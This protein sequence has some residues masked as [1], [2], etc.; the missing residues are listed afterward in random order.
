MDQRPG[1]GE[2]SFTCSAAQHSTA[3]SVGAF[4][5]LLTCLFVQVQ[6]PYSD[7]LGK[8]GGTVA[9]RERGRAPEAEAAADTSPFAQSNDREHTHVCRRRRHPAAGRDGPIV[10]PAG[11]GNKLAG[12][13]LVLPWPCCSSV[14]GLQGQEGWGWGPCS[15]FLL[16]EKGHWAAPVLWL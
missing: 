10:P 12:D 15:S 2:G 5:S 14:F 6:H 16:N 4:H 13:W 8:D 7:R 3:L 1:S 11:G 9:S